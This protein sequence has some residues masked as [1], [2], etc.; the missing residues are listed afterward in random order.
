[1]VKRKK[2]LS[3]KAR[4]KRQKNIREL[5]VCLGL[6]GLIAAPLLLGSKI[7]QQPH[8]AEQPQAP[9]QVESFPIQVY[10]H[11][12]RSVEEMDFEEYI[13]GVVSAEMPVSYEL[14]ALKAQAVAARTFAYEKMQNGAD[15]E[16]GADVC[17]SYEHCQAYNSL[18]QRK[19]K[20][21]ESFEKNEEKL[22]EAVYGTQGQILVYEGKPIKAFFHSTSGG[23]TENVEN[24][25]SQALPYLRSVQSAGEE[26]ATRYQRTVT[27]SCQQFAETIRKQNQK[28]T[29]T[30]DNVAKSIGK[31]T[32]FDSGRVDVI[33][34]GGVEFTG[35][36]IRSFFNLDSTNFTISV[37]GNTVSITTK[38]YGHGVGMS[39][40]GANAMAKQGND[41]QKIL[42]HYY[43]GV[44][45]TGISIP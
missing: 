9:T 27:F 39:Q 31:I 5:C 44:E 8:P 28:T 34:I 35:R 7:K 19:E 21:G 6:V 41:Y 26:D 20:W 3:K 4:L 2:R 23:M 42:F 11:Q 36:Q 33:E 29:I 24:V 37:S 43:T 32:R 14:E 10:D 45:L 15:D 40:V 22:R 30:K 13:L 25:Y 18:E 16:Q 1:M 38:G 17:T 12:N